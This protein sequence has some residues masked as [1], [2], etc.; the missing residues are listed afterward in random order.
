MH[1]VHK[2][3]YQEQLYIVDLFRGKVLE[4]D[5][6]L[7]EILDLCDHSSNEQ[8]ITKLS[9]TY[10]EEDILEAL[11]AL[12]E[13]EKQGLIFSTKGESEFLELLQRRDRPKLFVPQGNSAWFSDITNLP[14]GTNIAF[15][16]MV[17]CLSKHVDVHLPGN[18]FKELA[19][20]IYQIPLD[21]KYFIESPWRW[22]EYNYLGILAI[23]RERDRSLLPIFQSHQAPPV[24]LQIHAPRGHGGK[25]I[26]SILLHY[27]AM[28]RCD[29]FTGPSKSVR[30]FYARFVWDTDC[31]YTLYNGVDH[32][33][34]QPMDK[35]NAKVE[36]AQ[37]ANDER[38]KQMPIVGY[39]SR[40]QPEKGASI[41]L[42]LAQM[43]PEALFVIAGPTLGRYEM[44]EL[45][46]NVVYAGFQ[47]RDKLPLVYNSFD[48]YCFPTL[49]GEETFGL[50]LLEAMA[51]G[52]PPVTSSFDG[53][54]EVVGD[55]GLLVEAE[56]FSEDIGSIAG[57]VSPGA[58]A[59]K[60]WF[61]LKN[62][63]DRQRLGIKARERALTFSW[64]ITANN[65][66]AIFDELNHKKIMQSPSNF[67]VL[68]TQCLDQ[69][70]NQNGYQ[71][72]LLNLASEE[73]TSLMFPAYAQSVEEGLALSLLQNHTLHEVEAVLRYLMKDDSKASVVLRKVAG[74]V[75]A[76]S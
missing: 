35:Q 27:A 32:Q 58:L 66:L 24:L 53:L 63:I 10:S 22:E 50:T 57:Y 5:S 12:E 15:Y 76:T 34:F 2:F 21:L 68:F 48:I 41:F 13:I 64:E 42:K 47:P 23:H 74:F 16:H 8:I 29:A 59:E 56:T 26:N 4:I 71:S 52:V 38:I 70:G 18:S 36:L 20:G 43:I 45:P 7:W 73:Q 54:P 31:F 69:L 72:I 65:I 51:C 28:R 30:D 46:Y 37:I 62:E 25:E 55:A 33:L 60:I 11:A 39:L 3:R 44:R 9:Q 1:Q 14:T 40:V 75:G 19:E 6:L 17:E 49:S 67:P 61:L